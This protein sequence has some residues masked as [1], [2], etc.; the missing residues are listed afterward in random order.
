MPIIF[1]SLRQVTGLAQTQGLEVKG[2]TLTH[3]HTTRTD[4]QKAV[5]FLLFCFFKKEMLNSSWS[6][7]FLAASGCRV[8]IEKPSLKPFYPLFFKHC[9]TSG[10]WLCTAKH[11]WCLYSLILKNARKLSTG[12]SGNPG[13]YATGEAE[14]HETLSTKEKKS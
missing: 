8:S 6:F 11:S 13:R 5:S 3:V 9:S 12:Y 7:S 10:L 14:L 2:L 4:N 1:S